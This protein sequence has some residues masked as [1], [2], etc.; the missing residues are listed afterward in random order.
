MFLEY[1]KYSL[2]STEQIKY[3]TTVIV[4]IDVLYT[5]IKHVCSSLSLAF[6]LHNFRK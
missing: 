6:K 1:F 4:L 3:V 5:C 2:S